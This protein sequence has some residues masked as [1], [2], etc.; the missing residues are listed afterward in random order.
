MLRVSPHFSGNPPSVVTH[1]LLTT[2]RGHG[3]FAKARHRREA[4]GMSSHHAEAQHA[5]RAADGPVDCWM[6]RAPRYIQHTWL[7]YLWWRGF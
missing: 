2:G 5:M 3:I 6:N 1:V 7:T 4:R